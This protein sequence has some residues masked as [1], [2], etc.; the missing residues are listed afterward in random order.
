[1]MEQ[2]G[3]PIKLIQFSSML[4]ENL[5]QQGNRKKKVTGCSPKVGIEPSKNEILMLKINEGVQ[6]LRKFTF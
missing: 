1:M 5:K 6:R 3:Q 4:T 2:A